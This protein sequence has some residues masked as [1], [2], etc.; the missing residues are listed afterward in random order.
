MHKFCMAVFNAY[1]NITEDHSI[2]PLQNV[3]LTLKPKGKKVNK[4][5]KKGKQTQKEADKQRWGRKN[6]QSKI[7]S[8]QVVYP[9]FQVACLWCRGNSSAQLQRSGGGEHATQLLLPLCGVGVQ[10]SLQLLCGADC[11]S[12]CFAVRIRSGVS[13]QTSVLRLLL[14]DEGS[15]QGRRKKPWGDWRGGGWRD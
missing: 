13:P 10:P 6:R 14:A 4:A 11:R 2:M 5:C 12:V 9:C 1:C 3:W 15:R 7:T 8:D